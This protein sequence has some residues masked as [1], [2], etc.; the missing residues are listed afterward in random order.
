MSALR[1]L[2]P[3]DTPQ[4][5]E[6]CIGRL[7]SRALSSIY[8]RI[9]LRSSD[10]SLPPVCLTTMEYGTALRARIYSKGA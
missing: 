6:T 1:R 4:G 10:A 7:C 9:Q 5:V 8:N 2:F 3:L